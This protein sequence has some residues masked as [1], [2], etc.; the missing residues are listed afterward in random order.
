[1]SFEFMALH[2]AKLTTRQLAILALLVSLNIILSRFLSLRVPMGGIEGV[3][4]GFGPLPIIFA[5]LAF[6]PWAGFSAGALGDLVGY[7]INPLGGAYMPVFTLTAGLRGFFPGIV[8]KL[9]GQR[10]TF[11]G[12]LP[13]AIFSGLIT[14]VVVPFC[15]QYFFGVSVKATMPPALIAQAINVPIYSVLLVRLYGSFHRRYPGLV[16]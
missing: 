10:I 6:G 15:V 4:I 2:N 12:M 16:V 11:W 9:T 5:G 8:W 7:F 3:R 14:A 1:M 13:A